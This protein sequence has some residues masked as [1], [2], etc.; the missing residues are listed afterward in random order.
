MNHKKSPPQ[1]SILIWTV[2]LGLTLTTIFFYF[3]QRLNL[4]AAIQRKSIEEQSAV[5]FLESY[6][7][8]VE[9]LDAVGL[10][11]LSGDL[12]YYDGLITG[13]L[14][15][16]SKTVEGGLDTGEAIE[17][18]A[19]GTIIVEWGLCDNN[20]KGRP[21]TIEPEPEDEINTGNCGIYDSNTQVTGPTITL[22]APLAPLNYRL[23]PL[24]NAV[25][26]G[27]TWHLDLKMQVNNKKILTVEREF[28]F[29]VE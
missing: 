3:S 24:D 5:Q 14:I 2:M 1:G 18:Q 4:A 6:A 26:E 27:N 8:Y 28:I 23:S 29:D 11:T 7:D 15:N 17:Y 10:K 20:E 21:L 13:T 9:S 25:I 22:S 12:D 16:Q 19:N